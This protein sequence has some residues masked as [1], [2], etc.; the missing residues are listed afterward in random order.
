[1]LDQAAQILA[2]IELPCLARPGGGFRQ[3]TALP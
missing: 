1:M 3:R 2:K